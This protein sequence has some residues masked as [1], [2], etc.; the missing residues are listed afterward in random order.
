MTEPIDYS[1]IE[2]Q[3]GCGYC[4]LEKTCKIRDPKVNKAKL[5][6][7]F[8]IHFTKDSLLLKSPAKYN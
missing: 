8:F 2:N 5:G 6:C 4:T 1:K 3:I 7:E